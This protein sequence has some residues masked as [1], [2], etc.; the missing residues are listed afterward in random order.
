VRRRSTQSLEGRLH[1]VADWVISLA[2]LHL[3]AARVAHETG[4]YSDPMP[5]QSTSAISPKRPLPSRSRPT[6][7]EARRV[8][9]ADPAP[10][11][12][13]A[14]RD[15][16]PRRPPARSRILPDAPA[17]TRTWNLRVRSCLFAG[18]FP[19]FAGVWPRYRG[20]AWGCVGLLLPDFGTRFGTRSLS[21]DSRARS[22]LVVASM[23][24][25]GRPRPSLNQAG[26]CSSF[27]AAGPCAAALSRPSSAH[28]HPR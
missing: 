28:L 4:A 1:A 15:I 8:A 22:A 12:L 23:F 6:I 9:A 7:D 27:G 24:T 25:A 19:M 3:I 26:S 14:A 11:A 5:S 21:G 2:A 13:A 18:L 20:V 16:D 17:R 10:R